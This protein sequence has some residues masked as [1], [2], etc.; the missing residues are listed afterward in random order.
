M[1][2]RSSTERRSV[3]IVYRRLDDAR[4]AFL[5]G[6]SGEASVTRYTL[7]PSSTRFPIES[8]Q[9]VVSVRSPTIIGRGFAVAV[10]VLILGKR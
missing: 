10:N 4:R 7:R 5:P 1:V 2:V 6:R 9:T 8:V 3:V